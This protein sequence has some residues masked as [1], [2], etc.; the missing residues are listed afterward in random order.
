MNSCLY[1]GQLA[2]RRLTPVVHAFQYRL[3]MVYLDLAELDRVF[4]GRWLW[5]VER[6]NWATF[7][8]SDHL[9]RPGKLEEAVRDTVREQLGFAP[10]GPVRILTLLRYGGYCFNPISIYYC[11]AKDGT[12]LEAIVAEVHNTPW[13][14]EYARALDARQ[15]P[16]DGDYHLF[17]L[18]KEFHVSPFM[19]PDL[20]YA[21]RFTVP[22]EK[23]G[24]RMD[25]FREGKLVFDAALELERRPLS[26]GWL[27]RVLLLWPCMTARVIT[28]IYWQA[29]KLLVK[30]APVF[31]HPKHPTAKEGHCHP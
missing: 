6:C 25:L 18:D 8:R 5:S 12:T 19:P 2:H 21:W 26:G 13:G 4:S 30:G 1:V 23:L 20:R 16:S 14:E 31:Q 10:S 17:E 15:G 28:S 7:K 22:A 9:R 27:A 24:V 3:F 11:F 29:L